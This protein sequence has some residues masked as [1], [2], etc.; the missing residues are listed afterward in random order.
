MMKT[1]ATVETGATEKSA[2][3]EIRNLISVDL[4]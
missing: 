2:V 4:H 3:G 1:V